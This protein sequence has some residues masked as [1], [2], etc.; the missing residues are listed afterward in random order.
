MY[1]DGELREETTATASGRGYERPTTIEYLVDSYPDE[2]ENFH[3]RMA[4]MYMREGGEHRT[5]M[6]PWCGCQ[7]RSCCWFG[8]TSPQDLLRAYLDDELPLCLVQ[9]VRMWASLRGQTLLRTVRGAFKYKTAMFALVADAPAEVKAVVASKVTIL[10]SHQTLGSAPES[11]VD[12]MNFLMALY[13]SLNVAYIKESGPLPPNVE[14]V[15]C[16]CRKPTSPDDYMS[17]LAVGSVDNVERAVRRVG[18]MKLGEGKAENQ[19]HAWPFIRS[20]CVFVIDMNQVSDS[21]T[22]MLTHM[23]TYIH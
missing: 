2:W 14:I 12:D 21:Y 13:P 18:P 8:V 5:H 22:H 9:R 6:R 1:S 17:L 7:P 11:V 23:H 16:G 19:N 10:V 20:Q 3:H 4:P 15:T